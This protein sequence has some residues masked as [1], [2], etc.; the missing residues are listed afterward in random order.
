MANLIPLQLINFAT[1]VLINQCDG[2]TRWKNVLE[3]PEG[4]GL[5][6]F[7][8]RAK[9]WQPA[10]LQL[11]YLTEGKQRQE[12]VTEDASKFHNFEF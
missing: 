9:P 6:H 5:A 12:E 4:Q 7:H 10:E 3:V 11:Q 2:N 1:V 8:C